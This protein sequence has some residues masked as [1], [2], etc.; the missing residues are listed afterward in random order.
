MEQKRFAPFL[1]GLKKHLPTAVDGILSREKGSGF[2][3]IGFITTDDFYGCYITYD[4]S[5]CIDEYYDWDNQLEPETDFLYQ[6]L[7]DVVDS[8]QDID[9]CTASPEKWEF[10]MAYLAVLEECIKA[11]P[12]EVFARNGFDRAGVLFFTTMSDGDYVEELMN[13]SLRRFNSAETLEAYKL[14]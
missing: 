8:C 6:P 14:S 11:L 3:E 10:A 4:T 5:G 13:Q 1:E 7:V 9:L 12:E 2:C